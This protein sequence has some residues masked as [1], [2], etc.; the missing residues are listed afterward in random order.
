M[1]FL[2]KVLDEINFVRKNPSAFADKLL[3]FKNY[4]KGKIIKFPGQKVGNQTEEGFPAYEEAAKYLKT[5]KPTEEMIASKGLCKIAQDFLDANSDKSIEAID[6]SGLEAF[7]QKY[8][9]YEGTLNNA[10]DFGSELPELVAVNL[11]VSDGDPSRGNRELLLDPE[12][13]KIGIATKKHD[14][15]GKLTYIVS[16]TDFNNKVDKTD[17]EDFSG[18]E[19]DSQ[20]ST[21]GAP[22]TTNDQINESDVISCKRRERIIIEHGKK[23]KKIIVWKKFKNGKNKKEVKLLPL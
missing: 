11:I 17:A 21:A 14:E 7:I 5:L 8:G 4:F 23:K 6:E 2:Q 9:E 1:S 18:T 15:Y 22:S 16:C 3:T 19:P 20:Q 13:K 12:L 10:F